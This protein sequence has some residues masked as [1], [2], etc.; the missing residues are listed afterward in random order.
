[1]RHFG[2]ANADSPTSTT[3]FHILENIREIGGNGSGGENLELLSRNRAIIFHNVENCFL[4]FVDFFNAR[5]VNRTT[6]H[7]N[8]Q[9]WRSPY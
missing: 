4:K 1:M 3:N 7:K 5:K 2:K 9:Y 6:Q 8:A